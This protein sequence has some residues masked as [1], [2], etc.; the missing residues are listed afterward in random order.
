MLILS[1]L[2]AAGFV[3][4]NDFAVHGLQEN[5]NNVA[6]Q[7]E[8]QRKIDGQLLRKH[9]VK[10]TA[11]SIRQYLSMMQPTTDHRARCVELIKQLGDPSF[12]KRQTAQSELLR[13]P[14]TDLTL[15]K[16]ATESKNA[17]I[18]VRAKSVLHA[19]QSDV[20]ADRR[21]ELLL[22]VCRV[23]RHHKYRGLHSLL[24]PLLPSCKRQ[25]V[26]AEIT[27]TVKVTLLAKD[28]A[29][30]QP[31]LQ[32]EHETVRIAAVVAIDAVA[33]DASRQTIGKMLGDASD[34]VRLEAAFARCNRGDRRGLAVLIN[35]L[36]SPDLSI[37]S[38]SAHLLYALTGKQFDYAANV[39]LDDFLMSLKK[40]DTWMASDGAAAK[41]KFP[42]RRAPLVTEGLVLY[43]AFNTKDRQVLDG[44]DQEN[45]GS[46]HGRPKSALLADSAIGKIMSFDGR[47]DYI[48]RDYDSNSGLY[49]TKSSF[50]I[51]ACFKTS[52][53]SPQ[54]QTILSTHCAGSGYDGYKFTVDSRGAYK[55]KLVFM[56]GAGKHHELASRK[57]CNDGAWHHAVGIWDGKT[58]KLYIDGQLQDSVEATGTIPYTHRA[59]F[60]VGHSKSIGAAHARNKNYLFHGEIYNVRVYNRVLTRGEIRALANFR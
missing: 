47:D 6:S 16:Q 32:S 49:P 52:Q 18:R 7:Q 2:L 28:L 55:G 17:E 46:I 34:R 39:S 59:P 14:I 37:R 48:T 33:G 27:T 56:I 35:L 26:R 36:R 42:V 45:H 25:Y 5:K 41:L 22:A 29:E 15:L 11:K 50:S 12:A 30:L 1:V 60:T 20:A 51:S 54:E 23:I 4:S 40:W 53:S 10:P 43:Y 38:Q 58:A 3:V 31:F 21:S 8:Q 57:P 9:G 44:S 13:L 24:M 19:L